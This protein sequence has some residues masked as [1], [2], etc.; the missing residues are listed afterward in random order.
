MESMLVDKRAAEPP[1]PAGMGCPVRSDRCCS[2]AGAEGY[3]D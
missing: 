3:Q 1:V 2:D